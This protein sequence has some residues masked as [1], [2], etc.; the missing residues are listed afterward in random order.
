MAGLVGVHG[1]WEKRSLRMRE[2]AGPKFKKWE[3]GVMMK[4]GREGTGLV[5]GLTSDVESTRMSDCS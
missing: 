5:G 1:R 3:K 4:K 2:G